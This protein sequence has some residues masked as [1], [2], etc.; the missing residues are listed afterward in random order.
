MQSRSSF[1]PP[2]CTHLPDVNRQRWDQFDCL[3]STR[4]GQLIGIA[5]FNEEKEK[6]KDE[7]ERDTGAKRGLR[8]CAVF[9]DLN[10]EDTLYLVATRSQSGVSLSQDALHADEKGSFN[11]EF[12]TT[13]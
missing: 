9:D 8:L 1:P 12:C 4:R 5:H 6:K 2:F 13:K 3:L 10:N 7:T 11:F